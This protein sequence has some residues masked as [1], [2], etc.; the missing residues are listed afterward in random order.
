MQ[1]VILILVDGLRADLA[2]N[3]LA[4]GELPHLAA[5]TAR[6]GNGRAVT[7]FPSTTSVSYLPFLTGC[8][9]GR[10]N[11]PAI[12]W[13][14]RSHYAGRWWRDRQHV[15]SYCGYQAGM[16]DGDLPPDVPTIWELVADSVGIFTPVARGLPPG[17]NPA[18]RARQVWGA[19]AHFVAPVH[20]LEDRDAGRHLINEVER[21][22]RFIFAQFPAVDGFTHTYGPD[23]PQVRLAMRGLDETVG[24]VRGALVRQCALDDTLIVL[25]SDHGAARVHTHLDLAD[26]FRHRGVRT[27]SHPA[28]WAHDPQV[29]VAVS[30]N[31]HAMLYTEPGVPRRT[32]RSV[33]ELRHLRVFGTRTDLI[34]ELA[35]EPGIAFLVGESGRGTLEVI[36]AGGTAEVA[37]VGPEVV[38]Q[39]LTGDPLLLGGPRSAT[40]AEWVAAA[41]NDVYPN[42]AAQLLDQFRAPR[43]GDLVIAAREGWDLRERWEVPEHRA[44]HGSLVRSHMLVPLWASAPV[45]AGL[46]RSVDVFP[47]ILDWLGEPIPQGLCGQPVWLPGTQHR[48]VGRP[49]L[50]FAEV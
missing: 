17:R 12:R 15:R 20:R 46:I 27:L 2:E 26:W 29:A 49:T 14:D 28:L 25:V 7:T 47:A 22:R 21:H 10:L 40:V 32:R 50:D 13:L 3:L 41:Q 11:I 5:M 48:R 9:P 31:G 18:R 30:G 37:S 45:P 39:P 36:G 8:M 23:A 42:A 43:T 4:A 1:R 16:I 35:A 34:A 44:G 6:G 19:L 38:Y 33:A 24:R